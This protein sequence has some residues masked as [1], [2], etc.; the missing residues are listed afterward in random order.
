MGGPSGPAG[1]PPFPGAALFLREPHGQARWPRQ[2][3][4]PNGR[5][6]FRATLCSE[7][8]RT[9]GLLPNRPN[10]ASSPP[11]GIY[12]PNTILQHPLLAVQRRARARPRQRPKRPQASSRTCDT[13]GGWSFS[14]PSCSSG[15]PWLGGRE[16][17]GPSASA[18]IRTPRR[19]RQP[20]TA[21]AHGHPASIPEL[22]P[23]VQGLV[24]RRTDQRL[25]KPGA[26]TGPNNRQ[27]S[28]ATS[29]RPR[30]NRQPQRHRLPGRTYPLQQGYG[31]FDCT[32]T[33]NET[34]VINGSSQSGESGIAVS[35]SDGYAGGSAGS[36]AR[37]PAHLLHERR[38]GHANTHPSVGAVPVL[39]LYHRT[40][41]PSTGAGSHPPSSSARASAGN[42]FDPAAPGG[43]R[44]FYATGGE[45]PPPPG[46]GQ[47][48]E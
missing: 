33:E 18:G 4:T 43:G 30:Q 32:A 45:H 48:Q 11:E 22:S 25:M 37:L 12:G 36:P 27:S 1:R 2:Q 47:G 21:G 31:L 10:V 38:P 3:A 8:I 29:P 42:L 44:F 7:A 13:G 5:R 40:A 17:R 20:I 19:T 41:R 6:P 34:I 16:P 35:G 28:R 14:P 9:S 46:V 15:L 23:R 24:P 26:A 39:P